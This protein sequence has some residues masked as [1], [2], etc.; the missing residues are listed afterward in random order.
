MVKGLTL[1]D[2]AKYLGISNALF[3]NKYMSFELAEEQ[4]DYL[5]SV[6]DRMVEDGYQRV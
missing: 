2:I 3:S 4:K 6:I 1:S 5:R